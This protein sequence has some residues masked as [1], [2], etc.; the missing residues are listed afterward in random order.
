M[1]LTNYI[2]IFLCFIN[3]GYLLAQQPSNNIDVFD[4]NGKTALIRAI[5]NKKI[6]L[7]K[8]LLKKGA[9]INLQEKNGLRGT[10]LMYAASTGNLDLCKLLIENKAN[11][12]QLDI[13]KDHALNWAT[14][15]GYVDIMNLLIKKGTD[16]S[17]KSKHGTAVD[18]ALRLWHKDSVANVFRSSKIART[19]SKNEVKFI[20]ALKEKNLKDLNKLLKKGVSPNLKDEIGTPVLQLVSQTGNKSMV[21]FLVSKGAD[22]NYTNRVGQTPLTWASRF[23]HIEV[24]NLLLQFG[25]DAN[26]TDKKYQLT[27]LIGAA[28]G[29]N[30]SIGKKLIN[31][32]A[33]INHKDIINNAAAIHWA[34]FYNNDDF[35][36][37]LIKNGVDHHL[38]ALE[39]NLYSAY[40][41]A[42][43]YKKD[44]LIK[45]MDSIDVVKQKR[46]LVGSWK[47]L[48]IQYQYSD[49][50]Y[51][52]KDED[53]GRFLFS[54]NNYA[55]MYSPRMQKRK[56][57]INLSKP[58]LKEIEYAFK[59]IVFNTGN[60]ILKDNIITTTA[61]I[62]K[63]PGF[64]NGKQF[65]TLDYSNEI[66][67]L[68]M[69]DETYPNGK[70]PEWFGKIK[71]KF[72]LKKE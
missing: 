68:V 26:K 24:V 9:K 35:F 2:L 25:A 49:T 59:S 52:A 36:K 10:P 54:E 67:E 17:L 28:V 72:I 32:G 47:V 62:A 57:F 40:D 21:D 19:L 18:V 63:V 43:N 71:L 66:L 5:S 29:G 31:S 55:V 61:D 65:Y 7:V 20:K 16:L 38:K 56:P 14:F 23:G 12:N 51:V 33:K 37:L 30:I 22:V 1:K 6:E 41:M 48:E 8:T 34:I 69:F 15:Y 44:T 64:E 13:N 53:H 50:T 39:N 27:P 60:Y 4:E 45:F 11:I 3:T 70:K 46:K 42:K 58:D